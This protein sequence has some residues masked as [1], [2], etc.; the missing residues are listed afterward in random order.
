MGQEGRSRLQAS[1]DLAHL[2]E[3]HN[4]SRGRGFLYGGNQRAEAIRQLLGHRVGRVLDLGC[5]DG[6]LAGALGLSRTIGVDI[7]MLALRHALRAG[8]VLPL[9]ADLWRPLPV[10]SGAVDVVL[11]GELL[12]HMPFPRRLL[13]EIS[14]VLKPGGMAVGS[15]PNAFR[16]KNRIRFLFGR[17]YE[18]DPTHFHQFSLKELRSLLEEEFRAVQIRPCVGRLA[19]VSPRLLG[20]DLVWSGA[21]RRAV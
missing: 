16:L 2:Y 15:V 8:I 12:E 17:P 11:A 18:T 20:N 9:Q 5:R 3:T 10:A 7:D 21:L 13:R 19:R 6:A 14:R 1:S 4:L